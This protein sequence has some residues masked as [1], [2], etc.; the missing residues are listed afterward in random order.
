MDNH[1]KAFWNSNDYIPYPSHDDV[2]RP[3]S[4]LQW[5]LWHQLPLL[6]PTKN[7]NHLWHHCTK[8]LTHQHTVSEGCV[9]CQSALYCKGLL[10]DVGDKMIHFHIVLCIA[11]KHGKFCA[12]KA[13][14]VFLV[15]FNLFDPSKIYST[16]SHTVNKWYHTVWISFFFFPPRVFLCFLNLKKDWIYLK[17]IFIE[18]KNLHEIMIHNA[19]TRLRCCRW[20][21][22]THTYFS[23]IINNHLGYKRYSQFDPI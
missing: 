13:N 14:L 6:Y 3:V 23:W 1:V 11:W 12:L 7:P 21:L 10:F 19:V 18:E 4:H 20:I 9:L 8:S 22:V 17:A 5:N 15:Y 16:W 2:L